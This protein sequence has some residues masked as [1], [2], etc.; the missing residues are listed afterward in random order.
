MTS[1][2]EEEELKIQDDDPHM[3][4]AA[5]YYLLAQE[6]KLMSRVRN[7][8]FEIWFHEFFVANR[9]QNL[10]Y[11]T[12]FR[13]R[14]I[15][16]T[17]K[18]LWSELFFFCKFLCR[19]FTMAKIES[20]QNRSPSPPKVVKNS[21]VGCF[22]WINNLLMNLILGFSLL[23]FW[24]VFLWH[25]PSIKIYSNSLVVQLFYWLLN[26]K[27]A[28]LPSSSN[29]LNFVLIVTWRAISLRRGLLEN[30]RGFDSMLFDIFKFDRI[31][32]LF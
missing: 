27:N 14:L 13:F 3:A 32:Q 2:V 4:R 24:I 22:W 19:V 11:Y 16:N 28:I 9:Q 30:I 5:I 23:A 1:S 20:I 7:Y 12:Y 15:S 6:D 8:I 18:R 21:S 26:T 25:N 10:F 29:W 31:W 17:K